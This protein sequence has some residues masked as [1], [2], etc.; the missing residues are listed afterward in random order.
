M[1]QVS[2]KIAKRYAKA[3]FEICEINDLDNIKTQLANFLD[4]WTESKN[5]TRSSY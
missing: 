3:L 4:A 1:A 2:I 5:L